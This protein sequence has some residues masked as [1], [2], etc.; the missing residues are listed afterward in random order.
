M[1]LQLDTAFPSGE[2]RLREGS[3]YPAELAATFLDE[4]KCPG[5]RG[6]LDVDRRELLRIAYVRR[7]TA[8]PAK[9]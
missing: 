4:E 8:A 7:P 9:P 5:A 1:I 2:A 3:P 6:L